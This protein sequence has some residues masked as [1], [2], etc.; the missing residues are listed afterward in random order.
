MNDF[1]DAESIFDYIKSKKIRFK[2][3]EKNQM[4]FKLKLGS[5]G[6][7]GKSQTNS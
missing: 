5:I 6:T 4:E 2:N 7:G 1:T 3:V